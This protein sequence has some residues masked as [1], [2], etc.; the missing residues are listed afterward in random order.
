MSEEHQSYVDMILNLFLGQS[1]NYYKNYL[2]EI[3]KEDEIDILKKGKDSRNFI[4]HESAVEFIYSS[5][6]SKQIYNWDLAK[7]KE[8]IIAVATADYFVSRWIYEFQEVKSGY[9]VDKN[10]YVEK[11]TKWIFIGDEAQHL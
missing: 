9:F 11:I 6:Y 3:I 8:H 5:I 10:N 1:I 2:S 4:C 7:F